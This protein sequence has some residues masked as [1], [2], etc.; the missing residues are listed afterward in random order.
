MRKFAE[1]APEEWDANVFQ[2]IGREWM[3][4]T[5]GDR[6]SCNTMTASWGGLGVLWGADVSFAFVRPTRYTFEF[7]EKEPYYSLSF[8]GRGQRQAL[9]LCGTVS[10]RDTD[11]IAEA[12]LTTCYDDRAPYFAE[13]E[14]VLICRKMY[15]QDIDPERFEDPTI[16][17]HYNRSDYHRVYVGEIVKVLKRID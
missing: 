7:M 1:I 13:A 9:Q 12:G 11:K 4:I 6:K 16:A 14:V 3:L 5:A 17:S 10:G 2:K 8:F 15:T